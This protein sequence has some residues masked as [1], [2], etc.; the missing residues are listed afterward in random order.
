M[1]LV[2]IQV[3]D[4]TFLSLC[5][6]KHGTFNPGFC[7]HRL[8]LDFCA[9]LRKILSLTKNTTAK[10]CTAIEYL[11]INIEYLQFTYFITEITAALGADLTP[12]AL[13]WDST[14]AKLETPYR[15]ALPLPVVVN[16]A[17]RFLFF[18]D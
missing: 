5:H 17:F 16:L 3:L 14:L 9:I 1:L 7:W 12:G 15:L 13:H 2:Q 8:S 6:R 18:L 11:H 10:L 4:V